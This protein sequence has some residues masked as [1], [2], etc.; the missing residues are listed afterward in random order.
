MS[1]R[2]RLHWWYWLP[3]LVLI[4]FGLFFLLHAQGFSMGSPRRIGPG[5]FPTGISWLLIVLGAAV[6]GESLLLRDA[7]PELRFR[8]LVMVVAAILIWALALERLGLYPATFLLVLVSGLSERGFRLW[9]SLGL[10]LGLSVM[11]HAVFVYGLRL[12]FQPFA[13]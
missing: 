8:P 2:H 3:G 4:G 11:S 1:L 12:P 9:P 7:R 6:V 10:A 13:W 5:F